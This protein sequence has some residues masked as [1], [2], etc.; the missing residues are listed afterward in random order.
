M[1]IDQILL[2]VIILEL[3]S[4]NAK[5]AGRQR[6][7]EVGGGLLHLPYPMELQWYVAEQV[8]HRFPIV[9]SSNGLSQDH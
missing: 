4:P 8:G 9:G 5:T 1:Y 2:P 7:R 6:Q 3:L